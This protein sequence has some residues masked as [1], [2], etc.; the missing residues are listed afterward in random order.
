MTGVREEDIE[1]IL[2]LKMHRV[3]VNDILHYMRSSNVS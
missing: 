3:K 2:G 1:V